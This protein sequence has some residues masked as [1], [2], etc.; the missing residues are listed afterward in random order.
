MFLLTRRR[1]LMRGECG[2]FC[3]RC[4]IFGSSSGGGGGGGGGRDG[5]GRGGDIYV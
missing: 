2:A 4:L 5:R 3:E 1:Y